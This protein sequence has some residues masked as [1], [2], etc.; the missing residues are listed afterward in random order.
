MGKLR[1]CEHVVALHCVQV[2]EETEALRFNTGI[3]AMME[4]VNGANKWSNTPRG[5][6]EPFV[7]LLAPYAPHLAEELWQVYS[8]SFAALASLPAQP[9]GV[10][11]TKACNN[12]I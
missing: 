4:F 7:L 3:A 12:A 6:V 1:I 11:S 8:F 10:Q 5:A 2:T 9:L